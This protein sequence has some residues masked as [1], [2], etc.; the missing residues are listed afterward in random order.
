MKTPFIRL[1][2]FAFVTVVS[3]IAF[4]Q[5]GIETKIYRFDNGNWFTGKSFERRTFYSVDGLLTSKKPAR[6]DETIDLAGGYVIP[7]FGDAHTHNL[8]GTFNLDRLVA[9]YKNEGTFYVQVL[10]NSVSGARESR[11]LL[12]KPSTL[13]VTY[14]NGM[15]TSTYGHPF[16]V[17]EPLA[18]GIYNPAE[19]YRRIDE[20]KKSRLAL[21]DSYWFLDTTADV[22]AKWPSIIA[23]KPDLIKIGLLDANNK[24][25]PNPNGVDKGLFAG[26]CRICR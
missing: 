19:G 20:V 10:A 8:D 14:A 2:I 11:P 25:K 21:G 16:M 24:R 26:S 5:P 23:G 18:M 12:N 1:W 7:P 9:A 13:D 4:G 22:D 3:S 6:I 17:Y 15:L